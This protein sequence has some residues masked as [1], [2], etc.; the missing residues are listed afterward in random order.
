MIILGD[1]ILVKPTPVPAGGIAVPDAY[2]KRPYRG[3]VTNVGSG[4]LVKKG[5]S[6]LIP[7]DSATELT[8]GGEIFFIVREKDICAILN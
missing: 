2:T 7:Y 6:I 8:L 3:V 5:E 4:A 1:N